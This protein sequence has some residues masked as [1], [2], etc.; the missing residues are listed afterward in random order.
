MKNK[1]FYLK[2][3]TNMIFVI[4]IVFFL[5]CQNYQ[6]DRLNNDKISN[7]D[8]DNRKIKIISILQEL[9]DIRYS[10]DN[11]VE[12]NR[13]KNSEENR[14]RIRKT[15]D[16][17]NDAKDLMT[18]ALMSKTLSRNCVDS[19]CFKRSELRSTFDNT[20]WVAVEKLATK[21]EANKKVL[22]ELKFFSQLSGTD[23][24]DW[25]KIVDGKEFP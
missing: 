12:E 11:Q 20:F 13:L 6:S 24:G 16:K 15:V 22:D 25:E 14:L 17:L 4:L 21:K 10:D 2:V 8:F 1:T 18:L 3:G 7:N 5:S 9:G 23:I 19:E